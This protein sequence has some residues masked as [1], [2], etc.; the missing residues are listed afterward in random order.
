MFQGAKPTKAPSWRRDWCSARGGS[1]MECEMIGKYF[2]YF[3]PR[4]ATH[5]PGIALPRTVWVRLNRLC[6]GLTG[7]ARRLKSK[8]PLVPTAQHLISSSDNNNILVAQWVDHHWNS[9]W[10][11]IPQDF[12]VSSPT[13]ALTPQGDPPKKSLGPA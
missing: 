3:H 6:T 1:P 9:G 11:D 8:H 7:V 12:A 13:P 4:H 2:V 10:A 5:P